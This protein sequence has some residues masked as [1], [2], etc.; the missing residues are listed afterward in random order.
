MSAVSALARARSVALPVRR[1]TGVLVA[2]GLAVGAV[3]TLTACGPQPGAAA[4]INGRTITVTDLQ[5]ATA[6]L[7]AADPVSF[8]KVTNAQVLSVLILTPYAEQA[9]SAAGQGISDDAVREALVAAEQQ[10]GN[11]NVHLDKL[12]KVAMEALR[13]NIAFSGLDQAAQQAVIKRLQT[14]HVEVSPR[15][16]KF[17]K[18]TGNITTPTPNWIEPTAKPTATASPSATG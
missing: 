9:A 13:G 17:D 7:R 11:S 14:A 10:N 8:G 16:G 2:A 15:Y 18:A 3:L 4:T 6:S 1:R 5:H 12:D